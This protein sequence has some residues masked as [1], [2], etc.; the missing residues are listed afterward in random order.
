MFV[1]DRFVY[2]HMQKTG[3]TRIREILAELTDGRAVGRQ[4]GFLDAKPNKLV[5]GSIRN[6]LSWYV[7]LWAFGCEGRGGLLSRLSAYWQYLYANV[8]DVALFREWLRRIYTEEATAEMR[9]GY[10]RF[11]L[12]GEVGFMTYRYAYLYLPGVDLETAPYFRDYFE[13]EEYDRKHNMVDA[14]IKVEDLAYSLYAAL[15]LAGY[16]VSRERVEALCGVRANRSQHRPYMDYYDD[17]SVAL[18]LQREKLI[19]EKHGYRHHGQL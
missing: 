14:W 7:S 4:H 11:S 12:R 6:P 9:N 17:E 19:V 18:V 5:F 1:T 13:L 2:V 10:G 8:D 3:G 16:E 15:K